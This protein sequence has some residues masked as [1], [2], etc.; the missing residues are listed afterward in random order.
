MLLDYP[1]DGSVEC[2]VLR[3]CCFLWVVLPDQPYAGRCSNVVRGGG[4]QHQ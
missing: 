1:S 3:D 2:L 4:S